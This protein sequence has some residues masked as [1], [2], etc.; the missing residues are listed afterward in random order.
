M[1]PITDIVFFL[2]WV[3]LLIWAIR[4]MIRGWSL[5]T[6]PTEKGDVNGVYTKTVTKPIHPE[7][8]D[9]K[10]GEELMGVTFDQKT[11]CSLEE[12]QALQK[13]IEELKIELA[14]EDDDDD[15]DDDG[16]IIARV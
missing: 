5:M 12:Y 6:Q 10:P 15:E 16:D 3:F 2:T 7:M 13:R 11:S 4:T 1:N 14:M 8:V 9:V